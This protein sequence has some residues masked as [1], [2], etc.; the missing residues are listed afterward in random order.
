[1]ELTS[2]LM[3]R[4]DVLKQGLWDGDS[5]T[6]FIPERLMQVPKS[7]DFIP[8]EDEGVSAAVK[9]ALDQVDDLRTMFRDTLTNLKSEANDSKKK[10]TDYKARV[11]QAIELINGQSIS[12]A[13][14]LLKVDTEFLRRTLP[15]A[16][17]QFEDS[18]Q[19]YADCI[20][21]LRLITHQ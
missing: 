21:A 15:S 12:R 13:K 10:L 20:E 4:F 11:N 2:L 8:M 1:M 19:T 5:S 6:I 9:D 17:N 16:L 18:R 7:F 14:T 3:Q